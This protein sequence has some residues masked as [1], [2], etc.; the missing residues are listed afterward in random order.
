[1][2][3][4]RCLRSR[5]PGELFAE[6]NRA[7]VNLLVAKYPQYQNM[8]LDGWPLIAITPESVVSWR[9]RK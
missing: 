8:S 6:Y 7:A 1:M 9:A 3:S 4:V 5:P 2:L